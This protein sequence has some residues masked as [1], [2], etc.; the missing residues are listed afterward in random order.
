ML[1]EVQ[2]QIAVLTTKM[3]G[4]LVLCIQGNGDG[5]TEFPELWPALLALTE[6]EKTEIRL[7]LGFAK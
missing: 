6:D 2:K 7:G 4:R 3:V 5:A 1:E